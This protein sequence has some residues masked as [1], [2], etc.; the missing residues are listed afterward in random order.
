MDFFKYLPALLK[1]KDVSSEYKDAKGTGKPFFIS[2]RFVGSV[3][4]FAAFLLGTGLNVVIAPENISKILDNFILIAN[5]FN[6]HGKEIASAF[7]SIW[8]VVMIVKGQ[9]DSSK[10]IST[11]QSQV[12]PED[13][14]G[15]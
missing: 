10:R 2:K 6:D 5:I 4:A 15:A 8:G 13:N 3:L 11:P 7:G 12:P 1:L 14:S 9:I